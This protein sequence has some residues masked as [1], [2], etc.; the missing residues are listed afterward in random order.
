MWRVTPA[1]EMRNQEREREAAHFEFLKS[2]FLLSCPT[3]NRSLC[4]LEQYCRDE[5][6][7]QA[8]ASR[9][10]LGETAGWL[11]HSLDLVNQWLG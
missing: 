2:S 9:E 8:Q 5:D 4:I 1:E 6:I 7:K 3:T 10:S 11:R